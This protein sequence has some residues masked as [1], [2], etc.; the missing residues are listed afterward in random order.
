V[1]KIE[2]LG[3]GC[4]RC[5][6]VEKTVRQI[7]QEMALDAEVTKVKDMSKIAGYGLVYSPGLAINGKLA[8]G[9]GS[10]PDKARLTTLITNALVEQ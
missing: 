3:P 7:V 9:D 1:L 5:E 10:V 8:H 4:S 2:I 6:Q